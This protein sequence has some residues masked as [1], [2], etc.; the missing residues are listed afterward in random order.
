MATNGIG[1]GKLWLY[2]M[3]IVSCPCKVVL[4]GLSS[5]GLGLQPAVRFLVTGPL[6]P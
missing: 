4:G 6:S 2:L 3:S 5:Q 1:Y